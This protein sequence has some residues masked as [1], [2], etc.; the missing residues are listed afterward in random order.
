MRGWLLDL[1][2]RPD[3]QLERRSEWLY[4]QE[5]YREQ[6]HREVPDQARHALLA[7]EATAYVATLQTSCFALCRSGSGPN[8]IRLWESLGYG[9][10]P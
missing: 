9:A 7:E 2:P 1:P 10:T 4:Q 3:A 6:V 5:V 8:S